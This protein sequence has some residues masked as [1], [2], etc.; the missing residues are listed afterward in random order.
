[1][2]IQL[3]ITLLTS[4]LFTNCNVKKPKTINYNIYPSSVEEPI[5]DLIKLKLNGNVKTITETNYH[6][7]KDKSTDYSKFDKKGF[8]LQKIINVAFNNNSL[9]VLYDGKIELRNKGMIS[10]YNYI[11]KNRLLQN[12]T[13]IDTIF[14]I[15]SQ[16][17]LVIINI[18]KSTHSYSYDS[19]HKLKSYTLGI[20]STDSMATNSEK[21]I[22]EVKL[23]YKNN[24]IENV[25]E[26]YAY[27]GKSKPILW[28]YK[29]D[30]N[31]TYV[32][33]K[34]FNAT[35]KMYLN[36]NLKKETFH[37]NFSTTERLYDDY[38]NELTEKIKYKD[39]ETMYSTKE[40]DEM[41][42]LILEQRF[43]GSK[44]KYVYQL[45]KNNNWINKKMIILNTKE[46]I[47]ESKRVITYYTKT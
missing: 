35:S 43:T 9:K 34:V 18:E 27:T 24:K 38:G 17:S 46:V 4:I 1:M 37:D 36:C 14:K 25:I 30:A 41:N 28:E 47:V 10:N 44:L 16:H 12:F 21:P 23:N 42:N 22:V 15:D 7:N 20:H 45:D 33:E 2:R 32:N 39:G 19:N 6:K 40:Y 31:K 29:Y 8:L 13:Q 11:F 5:P 3:F 26:S